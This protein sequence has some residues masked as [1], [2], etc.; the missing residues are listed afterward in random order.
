[1]LTRI[2]SC[3]FLFVIFKYWWK[4]YFFSVKWILLVVVPI[5]FC[6]AYYSAC[7]LFSLSF[8][9]NFYY[10]FRNFLDNFLSIFKIYNKIVFWLIKSCYFLIIYFFYVYLIFYN[11]KIF[12]FIW[13]RHILCHHLI[14]IIKI[15]FFVIIIKKIWS[16][17]LN[18]IFFRLDYLILGSMI[19]SLINCINIFYFFPWRVIIDTFTILLIVR[20]FLKFIS[21]I[22]IMKWF[23]WSML[24]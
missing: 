21:V 4:F 1:M 19:F 24:L 6:W 15:N 20:C 2:S 3:I 5:H 22:S 8:L 9:R 16:F 14:H 7:F 13:I 12:L 11:I 10:F 18:Q 17:F 23:T